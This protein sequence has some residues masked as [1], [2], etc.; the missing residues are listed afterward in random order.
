LFAH[1]QTLSMAYHDHHK[2]GDV[3][4][5]VS[6]DTEAINQVLSNG[7]TDFTTNILLLGGIMVAMFFLN[8][9]LAS[10]TLLVLPLMLF[11][12]SQITRRSRTA[13]RN[14]QRNLGNLN[15]VMEENI[16]GIRIVKAFARGPIPWP[17]FLKSMR[18]T[19]KPASR[20][21]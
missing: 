9:P 15:A 17:N 1:I 19:G 20:P 12:T 21:M 10:G 3:M 6:N 2:V 14:V 4:S 8:W 13:Y 5:R 7:L 11:I 16:A 18:S